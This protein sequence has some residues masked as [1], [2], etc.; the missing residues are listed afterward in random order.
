M[1]LRTF[2]AGARRL[3]ARLLGAFVMI[4]YHRRSIRS[5]PMLSPNPCVPQFSDSHSPTRCKSIDRD[6]NVDAPDGRASPGLPRVR[7]AEIV[8]RAHSGRRAVPRKRRCIPRAVDDARARIGR[9]AGEPYDG[10]DDRT[11]E[12]VVARVVEPAG[13]GDRQDWRAWAA[14][15]QL[16]QVG[17]G[18]RRVPARR[19]RGQS[20]SG[21]AASLQQPARKRAACGRWRP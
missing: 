8:L 3:N 11:V 10:A 9:A 15:R 12:P 4:V 18:V 14:R 6:Q 17:V 20:A 1:S 16:A 13:D 2:L 19:A 7:A 21:G 5:G